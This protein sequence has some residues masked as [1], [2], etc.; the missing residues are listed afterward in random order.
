MHEIELKA[1][2]ADE[3]ERRSVEQRLSQFAVFAGE[4]RKCDEYWRHP[5]S[6][7][8]IRLRDETSTEGLRC[9]AAYKR[10]M[11]REDAGGQIYELNNEYEFSTDNR[12]SLAAF[13]SDAGFAVFF[14]KQKAVRSWRAGEVLIELCEVEGLG[15]FIEL[16][17]LRSSLSNDEAFQAEEQ[18]KSLLERCG[19]SPR[20]VEGRYYSELLRAKEDEI[21][22]GV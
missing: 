9:I 5:D 14:R 6:L 15:L 3:S 16:E 10:K 20:A 18:L 17:I 11:R 13:L 12:D 19:I 4:C 2:I 21:K 22:G 1:H 8:E 7:I